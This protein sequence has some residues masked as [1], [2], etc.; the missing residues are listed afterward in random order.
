V[1]GLYLYGFKQKVVKKK[2]PNVDT[3][4]TTNMTG[5]GNSSLCSDTRTSN[6]TYQGKNLQNKKKENKTFW[7]SKNNFKYGRNYFAGNVPGKRRQNRQ[8]KDLIKQTEHNSHIQRQVSCKIKSMQ[9]VC[10]GS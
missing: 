1:I 4:V 7:T 9:G 8:G 5:F 6:L 10:H 3:F 2:L